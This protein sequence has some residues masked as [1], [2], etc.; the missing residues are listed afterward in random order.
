[1]SS[2]L[3][4][5]DST[6]L[7]N[8]GCGTLAVVRGR[9]PSGDTPSGEFRF[10]FTRIQRRPA[11]VPLQDRLRGEA[12]LGTLDD[13]VL[14]LVRSDIALSPEGLKEIITQSPPM[15][16]FLLQSTQANKIIECVDLKWM[17]LTARYES[18]DEFQGEYDR[19]CKQGAQ[20]KD[21]FV[22][23]SET[24]IVV[25]TIRLF[26]QCANLPFV[27]ITAS[28]DAETSIVEQ[29]RGCHTCAN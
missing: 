20:S 13:S 21:E 19:A 9:H 26:P 25:L 27:T 18:A 22:E 6:Y 16:T 29:C 11:D 4:T 5:L 28:Y 14:K 3:E 7:R 1:M 24:E 2:T 15:V 23:R 8:C 12:Y 17:F 10:A